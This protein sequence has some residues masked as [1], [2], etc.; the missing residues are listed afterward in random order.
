MMFPI[1]ST[2]RPSCFS[3]ACNPATR[4]AEG[5]IST[6]RRL[7]PR[8]IGTPM[9][10][11]FSAKLASLCDPETPEGRL[12]I[13]AIQH[14]WKGDDLANVLRS[15]NPCHRALEAQSKARVRN[16]AVAPQVQ[17]PL[18]GFFRQLL[19]ANAPNQRFVVRLALA[20]PDNLAVAFRR[21]HVKTERKLGPLR[22]HGHV[23][24]FHRGGITMDDDGL[25]EV[26][27]ENRLFV[28][29][30]IVAPFRGV[31]GP[32]Q[33]AD[34]FVIADAG[35]WRL[36]LCEF[37]DV[38]LQSLEFTRLVLHDG[39]H[40]GANESFTETNH[41]FEVR[42]CGFG[43]EHPELGQMPA[44]LRL[45]GAKCGTECVDLPQRCGRRFDVELP[46]LRKISLLVV[47]IVHF[48]ERGGAFAC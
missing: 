39:L 35:K 11:I 16:A 10:R 12:R 6:P 5:P 46:R 17:I 38:A 47:D 24:G 29:A 27:G 36:D 2:C 8:S 14:P 30:E 28:A 7:A 44:R 19:F 20:S 43:L 25:V 34:S 41:V 48:E 18:K 31:S 45:F 1:S 4:S 32:L 40:D 42:K 9:I 13:D 22:V 26:L 37:R 3:F 15:A 33:D 21:N 23:E